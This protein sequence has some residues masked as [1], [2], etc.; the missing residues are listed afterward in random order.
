MGPP[1]PPTPQEVLFAEEQPKPVQEVHV[2][3][4]HEQPEPTPY[5]DEYPEEPPSPYY[6][7]LTIRRWWLLSR[8]YIILMIQVCIRARNSTDPTIM[9]DGVFLQVI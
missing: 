2:T 1:P 3:V 6:W 9:T 7:T 4:T 8:W 5:D